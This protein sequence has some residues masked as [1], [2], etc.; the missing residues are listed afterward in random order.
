[1]RRARRIA[2]VCSYVLPMRLSAPADEEFVDYVTALA[3]HVEVV[4][5]DGSE[6]V[7]FANHARRLGDKVVHVAPDADVREVVNGK[8]AGVITGIRRVRWS[9]GCHRRARLDRRGRYRPGR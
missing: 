5:V 9:S 2:V 6:P 3:S 7:V 1:M 8:V 4:V